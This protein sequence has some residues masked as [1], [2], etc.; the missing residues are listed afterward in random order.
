MSR[1]VGLVDYDTDRF[2]LRQM[3]L[4][5]LV[6]IEHDF[7]RDKQEPQFGSPSRSGWMAMTARVPMPVLRQRKPAGPGVRGECGGRMVH[8]D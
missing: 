7:G 6:L 4:L 1:W 8:G 2:F 3:I 5:R